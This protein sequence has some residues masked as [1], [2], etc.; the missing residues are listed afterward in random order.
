M[1]QVQMSELMWELYRHI[2]HFHGDWEEGGGAYR[3]HLPR[4]YG[5]VFNLHLHRI[6]I[7]SLLYTHYV[8]NMHNVQSTVVNRTHHYKMCKA[9]KENDKYSMITRALIPLRFKFPMVLIV[10]ISLSLYFPYIWNFTNALQLLWYITS[11]NNLSSALY[12]EI[13]FSIISRGVWGG[14]MLKKILR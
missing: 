4:L 7:E 2:L 13:S 12:T 9:S 6:N 11:S 8:K 14:V 1:A 3:W 5:C 10:L